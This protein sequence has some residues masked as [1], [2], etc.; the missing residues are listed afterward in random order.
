MRAIIA[1]LKTLSSDL[2]GRSRLDSF[3]E[4]FPSDDLTPNARNCRVDIQKPVVPLTAAVCN[5]KQIKGETMKFSKAQFH[6]IA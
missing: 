5:R 2:K 3:Q 6:L 1:Y 4:S